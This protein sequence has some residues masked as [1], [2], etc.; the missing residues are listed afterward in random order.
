MKSLSA[1]LFLVLSACG[2][3]APECGPGTSNVGGF[4]T[5][6]GSTICG[7]GTKFDPDTGACLPDPT[8]CSDGTVLING[9]CQGPTAGLT[10]DLEEGPAFVFDVSG[11]LHLDHDG[12]VAFAGV[13]ATD[14][15]MVAIDFVY[16]YAFTPPSYLVSFAAATTAQALPTDGTTVTAVSKT[17]V[18]TS[19]NTTNQFYFDADTTPL[20]MALASTKQVQGV[21]WDSD[22]NVVADFGGLGAQASFTS[23][24]GLWRA[25]KAG[26]YLFALID[27]VDGANTA[28]TITSTVAAVAP[29]GIVTDTPLTGQVPNQFQTNVYTL[30]LVN[31]EWDLFDVTTTNIPGSSTLRLFDHATAAG[32][33]DPLVVTTASGTTTLA[34]TPPT[35]LS[36]DFPPAGAPRGFIT[37]TLPPTSYFLTVR[38]NPPAGTPTFDLDVSTRVYSDL[39][40]TTQTLASETAPLGDAHRYYMPVTPGSQVQLTVT[41]STGSQDPILEK[42]AADES[43]LATSDHPA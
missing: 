40:A 21:I 43:V 34:P 33:L 32:R 12:E 6:D 1:L 23:F 38:T 16:N 28:F 25:P 10:I 13:K 20:G 36:F 41:P 27:P 3:N 11:Q 22:L 35:L 24:D 8:L 7:D 15:T 31:N 39:T 29:P 4:C 18:G 9:T 17:K 37:A 19:F 2:D 26:R 5:P 30:Q 42:F 14:T